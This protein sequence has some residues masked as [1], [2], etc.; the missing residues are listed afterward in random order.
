MFAIAKRWEKISDTERAPLKIIVEKLVGY[1]CRLACMP[2]MGSVDIYVWCMERKTVCDWLE[3]QPSG[4]FGV[5]FDEY[6]NED[7]DEVAGVDSRCFNYNEEHG[8]EFVSD[9]ESESESESEGS[10]DSDQ[11]KK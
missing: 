7:S 10:K 1:P 11:E 3:L 2:N 4:A 5:I 8:V 9:S 6:E